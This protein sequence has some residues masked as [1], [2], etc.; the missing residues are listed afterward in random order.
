MA[1]GMYLSLETIELI[2]A[3]INVVTVGVY[4]DIVGDDGDWQFAQGFWMTVCSAIL[5]FSCAGFLAL[6]SFILPEF[7]KRGEMELSGP[8]RVFVIQIMIFI[9]WLALYLPKLLSSESSGAAIFFAIEKFTFSESV[10]FVDVTVTTVGFG[11]NSA[12]I[13]STTNSR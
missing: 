9:F 3:V 7:G 12:S 8:Q 10:Y 13:V 4:S 5:S 1:P 6:N 11:D 2:Q